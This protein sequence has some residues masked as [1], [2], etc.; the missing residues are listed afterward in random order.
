MFLNSLWK[1]SSTS[2]KLIS[3]PI[4]TKNKNLAPYCL[5]FATYQH[6]HFPKPAMQISIIHGGNQRRATYKSS[7]YELYRWYIKNVQ[8]NVMDEDQVILVYI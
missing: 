8:I 6:G 2:D 7:P 1:K 3:P 5:S 4:I